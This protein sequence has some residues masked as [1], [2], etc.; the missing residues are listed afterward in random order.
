MGA[1]GGVGCD[2]G[3][4]QRAGDAVQQGDQHQTQGYI[5]LN[6]SWFVINESLGV[7]KIK[8]APFKENYM[9]SILSHMM[10][11]LRIDFTDSLWGKKIHE[12]IF[13]LFF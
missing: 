11:S 9:I 3:G 12:K 4:A 6:H 5:Y 7:E 2:P 8:V 13:T 10:S 1:G